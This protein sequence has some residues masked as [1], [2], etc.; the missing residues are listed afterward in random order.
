MQ[1]DQNENEDPGLRENK[2]FYENLYRRKSPLLHLLHMLVSFDQQ[3][4]A[5][6][7][8]RLL[9]G[10]LK[11]NDLNGRKNTLSL[12]DFGSGWGTFLQK[13]PRRFK[14]YCFDLSEDAMQ[15]VCKSLGY[16]GFKVSAAKVQDGKIIEPHNINIIV[17]SHVLEHVNSDEK[18]LQTFY[19]ALQTDGI[20]LVNVPINE[21]WDDPKHL[22]SYTRNSI[23][24]LL[25]ASGFTVIIESEEDKWTG[26]LL[27][28]E[29]GSAEV[30]PIAKFIIRITRLI[31]AL[32]PIAI[33][34][35]SEKYLFSHRPN[36]QILIIAKKKRVFLAKVLI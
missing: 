30:T 10:F 25:E 16:L 33:I 23:R 4:K 14:L 3:S 8:R 19:S 17:C 32:T 34:K 6:L 28:K 36:Q 1:L 5:K 24:Q 31:L 27:E 9:Q 29:I 7:N 2:K 11:T 20:L 12:L 35:W 26:F 13:M 21:V 22:R 18:I 15:Q